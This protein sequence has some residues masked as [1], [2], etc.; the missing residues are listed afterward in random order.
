MTILL[1]L[2][3][4]VMHLQFNIQ[5]FTFCPHCVNVFCIY[6]RTNSDFC[7]V[8][9]TLIGF[10]NRDEKCLQR[11]TNCVF[12]LNSLRFVFI[13]LLWN[14]RIF[15]FVYLLEDWKRKIEM[16]VVEWKYRVWSEVSRNLSGMTGKTGG[17][18]QALEPNAGPIID[19]RTSVICSKGDLFGTLCT[20]LYKNE[21][22][23]I[24]SLLCLWDVGN[25]TRGAW[26]SCRRNEREIRWRI[27]WISIAWKTNYWTRKQCLAMSCPR[28]RRWTTKLVSET[29]CLYS[30]QTAITH[31]VPPKTEIWPQ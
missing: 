28:V 25:E 16:Y 29:R 7:P 30:A 21:L 5:Q 23:N 6:L 9:N 3:V 26:K 12:K 24:Y 20:R 8:Q 1:K 27:S 22:C 15:V 2:T 14:V 13:G 10:Y 18:L 11:G 4:Y 31:H 19:S 17:I